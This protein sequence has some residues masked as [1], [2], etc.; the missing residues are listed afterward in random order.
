MINN[1]L[2]NLTIIK[3]L[4]ITRFY[5]ETMKSSIEYINNDTIE[6]VKLKCEKLIGKLN[7]SDSDTVDF[8]KKTFTNC[9]FTS[10][11]ISSASFNNSLISSCFFCTISIS[12]FALIALI[13]NLYGQTNLS[14]V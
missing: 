5:K 14:L 13:K 2:E 10:S 6:E 7:S 11:C 1:V 9:Y 12:K 8:M 3:A 4:D